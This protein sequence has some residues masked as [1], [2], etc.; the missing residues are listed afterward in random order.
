[1]ISEMPFVSFGHEPVFAP[2]SATYR[3]PEF[4]TDPRP[5]IADAG[6][7]PYIVGVRQQTSVSFR[8]GSVEV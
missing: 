4:H 7:F 8:A 1:V 3:K 5:S 6:V 2:S